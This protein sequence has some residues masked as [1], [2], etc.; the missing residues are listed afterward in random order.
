MAAACCLGQVIQANGGGSGFE[1]TVSEG[2]KRLARPLHAPAMKR[3]QPDREPG[4]GPQSKQG[5]ISLPRPVG[6]D[7]VKVAALR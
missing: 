2:D 1:E 4:Q 3:S 7:N 5:A 6:P